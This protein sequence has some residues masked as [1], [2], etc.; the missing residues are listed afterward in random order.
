[1]TQQIRGLAA[2]VEDLSSTPSTHI[3]NRS[4]NYVPG[5]SQAPAH[6]LM[7]AH[8]HTHKRKY[9]INPENH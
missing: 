3:R 7:Q 4:I 2:L 1:M 8:T 9:Y 5:D 6:K